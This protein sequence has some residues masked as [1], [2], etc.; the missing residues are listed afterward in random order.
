MG[1]RIKWSED[2]KRYPGCRQPCR[3]FRRIGKAIAQG[4]LVLCALYAVYAFFA[5]AKLSP[6]ALKSSA[7]EANPGEE[8]VLEALGE[9]RAQ[10]GPQDEDIG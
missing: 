10:D 3:G 9:A 5:K 7:V 6:V 2:F 8:G 4:L 1:K